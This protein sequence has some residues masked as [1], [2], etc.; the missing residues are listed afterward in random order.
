MLNP[1]SGRNARE[2]KKAVIEAFNEVGASYSDYDLSFSE[3][4]EAIGD[5]CSSFSQRWLLKTVAYLAR[6]LSPTG[7]LIVIVAGVF[8]TLKLLARGAEKLANIVSGVG[9]LLGFGSRDKEDAR[10]AE[11][12]SYVK[13][14]GSFTASDVIDFAGFLPLLV[15]MLPAPLRMIDRAVDEILGSPSSTGM[16]SSGVAFNPAPP[17][18]GTTANASTPN[19]APQTQKTA[20][21]L[22]TAWNQI[23]GIFGISDAY[24]YDAANYPAAAIYAAARECGCSE[25]ALRSKVAQIM[26]S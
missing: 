8:I 19:V 21:A 16:V 12:S 9:R 6:Y 10:D 17:I 20:G 14:D 3:T 23:K 5:G 11:S 18:S 22:E 24:G 25:E 2:T 1:S 7:A 26:N 13:Y 15:E 4:L